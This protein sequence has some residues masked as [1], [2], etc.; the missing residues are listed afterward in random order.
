MLGA[1][2]DR[3]DEPIPSLRKRLDVARL[4]G[5][6]AEGDAQLPDAEAQSL[7]ELD[8][9]IGPDPLLELRARD[10]GTGSL[11]EQTQDL[12]GLRRQSFD[13]AI[14]RQ[15]A[16]VGIEGVGSEATTHARIC[17]RWMAEQGA[18]A[19]LRFFSTRSP[20]LAMADAEAAIDVAR[21]YSRAGNMDRIN[22]RKAV[23]RLAAIGGTLWMGGA[24]HAFAQ[25]PSAVKPD[26]LDREL[27]RKFVV[28][29]HSDL[30][31]VKAMLADEPHLVNAT[32]DWGGGDFETALGG[33][34]HMARPD[35]ARFL[36]ENGA[37][38]DLFCATMMGRIEVVRRCVEDDAAIVHVKGPHGI[39]LLRH[40]EMAHQDAVAKLLQSAGA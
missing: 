23:G 20:G 29:A 21:N 6:V 27:V 25:G 7:I 10:D 19:I 39:S 5:F 35:I 13:G 18:K 37:R 12:R 8:R 16:A 38:M 17:A 34:S 1:F 14:A 40:A 32:W 28:A 9:R 24:E 2:R 33:A 22:R 11:E 15:I 30:D 26:P 31:T 36:L 4:I 3:G